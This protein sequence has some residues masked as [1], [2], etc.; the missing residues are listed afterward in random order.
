MER[1]EFARSVRGHGGRIY[2]V[3]V[4]VDNT[5]KGIGLEGADSYDLLNLIAYE[6][7]TDWLAA[8]TAKITAEIGRRRLSRLINRYRS[9]LAELFWLDNSPE[10]WRRV[11]MTTTTVGDGEEVGIRLAFV[12]VGGSRFFLEMP[13]TSFV[14]LVTNIL[15]QTASLSEPVLTTVETDEWDRLEEVLRQTEALVSAKR[16]EQP[17]K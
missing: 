9:D 8:S 2:D 14:R 13:S 15:R 5:L 17:K 6:Q 4:A 16:K 3:I 12:K 11:S 1:L 10:D 7:Y